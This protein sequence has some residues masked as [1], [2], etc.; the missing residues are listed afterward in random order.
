V[1]VFV[2]SI[3]EDEQTL[4]LLLS[5]ERRRQRSRLPGLCKGREPAVPRRSPGLL[6][7]AEDP[8]V[9]GDPNATLLSLAAGT[10]VIA[11]AGADGIDGL[12]RE[13]LVSL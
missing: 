13:G 6:P 10:A 1:R 11:I 3:G 8:E 12:R 9:E 5:H 2:C 4:G 7:A